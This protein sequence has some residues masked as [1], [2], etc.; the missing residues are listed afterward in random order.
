MAE[1]LKAIFNEKGIPFF[2][3]SPTNQQF[4][5]LEKD[6]AATL[7]QSVAYTTWGPYDDSHIIARFVT[8][9][10]TTEADLEALAALL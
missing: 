2:R 1:K 7:A 6:R 8:S 3:E 9:W 5:I 10:A 4:V